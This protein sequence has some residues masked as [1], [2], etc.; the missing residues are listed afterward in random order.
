ME[1]RTTSVA[2]SEL[3]RQLRRLEERLER[4]EEQLAR[5]ADA[6]EFF[7]RRARRSDERLAEDFA[8]QRMSRDPFSE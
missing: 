5:V 3:V 8:R 4:M 2:D 6:G 7:V 1:P